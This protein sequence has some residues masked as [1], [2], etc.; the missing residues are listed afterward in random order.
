M[1]PCS[2]GNSPTMAVSRS[3]LASWAARAVCARVG[4]DLRRRCA[5]RARRCARCARR[6]SR[7]CAWKVTASRPARRL[8]SGC[9]RS[10]SQKNAASARRGRTTRSLPAR[11]TFGLGTV[12]VADGDEAR[13]QRAGD[14]SRARS[15][16]DAPAAS[17]ISTSRGSARKRG[18]NSSGERHRPFHQRGDLIEQRIVD[19]RAAAEAARPAARP[20]RGCWRGAACERG[21]HLAARQQRPRVAAGECDAQRPDRCHEAMA[22]AHVART[23]R[24]AA[25]R[26]HDLACRTASPASAPAARTAPRQ[27]P[28]R[29]R[30]RNRQRIERSAAA[31]RQQRRWCAAPCARPRRQVFDAI[32]VA[33]APERLERHAAAGA[34]RRAR[35]GSARPR[36]RS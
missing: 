8:A 29:M 13:Q 20:A 25:R 27:L 24:R 4:A 7:A 6:A 36:R 22:E 21:D 32:R 19:D 16:A 10:C 30:L 3:H 2:S 1:M 35:R 28:Q 15:S 34:R 31:G 26:R 23:R 12:D 18:S 11:T 5:R 9:R 17:Q 14:R 33:L